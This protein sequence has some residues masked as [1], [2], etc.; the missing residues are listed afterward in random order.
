[1]DKQPANQIKIKI[2][3]DDRPF[4][5]EVSIHKWNESDIEAAATTE[6]TVE[7]EQFDW[8][9]PEVEE[10]PVPEFKKIYYEPA[11]ETGKAIKSFQKNSRSPLLTIIISAGTAISIGVLFGLIMLKVIANQSEGIS[12]KSLGNK[13]TIPT[14]ALQQQKNTVAFPALTTSIIQGGVFN[15]ADA[16][17]PAN[18][19]KA[20]G[21]PTA[22][23]KL[24][25]KQYI[26]IGVSGDLASAKQLATELKKQ[27]V[28]VFAK[29]ITFD[30]KKLD[31]STKDE[32][33]FI[34]QTGTLF[35]LM[36]GITSDAYLSSTI[37]SD[38]LSKM[39]NAY[40]QLEGLKDIKNNH[41]KN[42]YTAQTVCYQHLLKFQKNND[43]K[44]ILNAEQALL[45]YLKEYSDM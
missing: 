36:A 3:G 45:S 43:Q 28:E 16:S 21:L 20:K 15:G 18:E 7:E 31:I 14:G 1:M 29:Q 34:N 17:G 39:E 37:S 26:F 22:I 44:E 41:L 10:N 12:Q 24:D 42:L 6:N 38:E 8:V 2:N 13:E 30:E 27:D 25:G 5:E 23:L 40:K 19:L 32:K 9:L 35:Q 4:Q 11:L 33:T